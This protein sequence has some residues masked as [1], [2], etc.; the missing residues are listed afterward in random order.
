MK[1]RINIAS[2][3]LSRRDFGKLTVAAFSGVLLGSTLA[4]RA[5]D[6][7]AKPDPKLLLAEPH[8]CRGLNTCKGKGKGSENACAGQGNCA[9]AEKHSCKGENTCKGQG[10]CGEYPGQN[11]CKGLGSCE[12]P[13][14]EK[15]WKTARKAFEGQM[16]KAGKTF[17]DAPKRKA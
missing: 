9:T 6:K 3:S 12:V 8:T 7:D 11:S 5:A 15:T 14:K 1:N 13:L 17:G 4:G 2:E 16:K 10:G